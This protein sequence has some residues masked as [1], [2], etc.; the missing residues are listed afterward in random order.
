MIILTLNVEVHTNNIENSIPSSAPPP[1][2]ISVTNTTE[3]MIFRKFSL[4]ILSTRGNKHSNKSVITI[5]IQKRNKKGNYHET[6][7]L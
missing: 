1:N 7:S 2:N 3:L 4:N 5:Q 6:K